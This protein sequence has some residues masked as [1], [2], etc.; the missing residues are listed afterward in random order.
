MPD[1]GFVNLLVVAVVALLA[2]LAVASVPVVRVPGV[3]VEIVAGVVLGPQV[4]GVVSADLVVQVLSVIGL[5]FLL[6][7]VGLELDVRTLRGTA[8]RLAALGY[9][10]SLALGVGTGLLAAAAGWVSSP[11]LVAIALSATSLGLVVPVLKDSGHTDSPAARLTVAAATVADVAAIVLLTL[12]FSQK[13]TSL[14][15][16]VVLL[17][18]FVGVVTVTAVAVLVTERWGSLTRVIRS[19]QDTTAEIRVRG[20]VVLLV[21]FVVLAQEFGL[22]AILGALLAGVVIGAVDRDSATHPHFRTKLDAIGFGFLIPVFFVSSGIRLDVS[23]LVADPSALVRMPVF[24]LALLVVRGLPALLYRRQLSGRQVA[25]AAL[26]QAT[27]LPF[28]V[29]AS[30][31]GTELGLISSVNAAALVGAGVASVLVFPTIALTLLRESVTRPTP[32][33]APPTRS[34]LESSAPIARP[35]TSS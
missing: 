20:A 30:M 5:A 29:T 11:A 1:T 21:G 31:I 16:R 10:V 17:T 19:L 25:A 7:T 8:L 33:A 13:A 26:L 35:T 23:G 4:L 3:V 12:L 15:A 34:A 27:S 22:E 6:F 24:L 28:L 14:G 2:P 32:R 18:T 9:A